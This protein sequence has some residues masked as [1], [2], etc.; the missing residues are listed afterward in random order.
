[1]AVTVPSS[2][3]TLGGA[4]SLNGSSQ[5]LTTTGPTTLGAG[6]FT[7]ELFVRF[8]A[9]P[10]AG[11]FAS[12]TCQGSNFRLF[13]EGSSNA[14]SV[15]ENTTPKWVTN[16]TGMVI[17]TWYHVCVM[18]TSSTQ[19][20]IYINGV[21]QTKSTNTTTVVTYTATG[22]T[23][24]FDN[25]SS[26][27]YLNGLVT[28]QRYVN[29]VAMY[30]QGGFQT[31]N[32]PLTNVTGT[33]LLLLAQSA[34]TFTN[35]SSTANTGGTPYTVTATGTPTYSATTPFSVLGGWTIGPGFTLSGGAESTG[36]IQFP[37]TTNGYGTGTAS[38]TTLNV[39]ANQ[40]FTWEAWMYTRGNV[41]GSAST[42]YS[43][44]NAFGA[45]AFAVFAP[46]TSFGN[47]NNYTLAAWSSIFTSTANVV[48]NTWTH[49]AV[50][51]SGTAANNVKLYING[52]NTTGFTA[53]NNNA[54]TSVGGN[55]CWIGSSGDAL[56]AL[57]NG[58][59]TNMRFVVGTAVYTTNF[60]PAT[61]P[62]PPT[63]YANAFGTPSAQISSGT[64]LLL[65]A[66]PG[67]GFLT[68]YTPQSGAITITNASGNLT[69]NT[70]TPFS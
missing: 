8:A 51:R 61:A 25:S 63:Q 3:L 5:Y 18:R 70:A 64:S 22:M 4:I 49:L 12:L 35:D 62:L 36:S 26:Q 33:Q 15:W 7:I 60:T 68:N 42:I 67:A 56:G 24:G 54:V 17:N 13:L 9:L 59:I 53:T 29:G 40:D 52:N 39:A 57:F 30:P 41:G 31:P 38:S 1:M 23:V 55:C 43:N 58:F 27:Y 34:G 66:I 28:N 32:K 10:G 11:S 46:H 19:V 44:Y 65:S 47:G 69:S 48:Q 16:A 6:I 50:V 21:L 2:T 37:G 14:L 20:D 45:T